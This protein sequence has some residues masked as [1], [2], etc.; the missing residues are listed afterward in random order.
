MG[1]L[2]IFLI[3]CYFGV[4][5]L[6]GGS[7]LLQFY[8]NELVDSRGWMTLEGLGNLLAISQVTPGPIG[9]NLATFI[10]YQQGGF[11]GGL[12]ATIG[13]LTP[14]FFLMSLAVHSYHKWQDSK[15]VRSLLFGVKPVM[16]A[17][18]LTALFACLGMSVLTDE[19]PFDYIY[20][21]IQ[22][23]E[24]KYEE[25]LAIRW[26]TLPVLVLSIYLLRYRKWSIMQV[27]F[28]S[29]VAGVLLQGLTVLIQK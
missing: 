27:I 6:S 4:L 18:I 1:L 10:G 25:D 8:I 17:L 26:Q 13:L 29:A 11:W 3:F 15:L 22:N 16:T 23:A 21:K 14:S 20:Q 28:G 2:G 12:V 24:L 7:S 19:L 5:C 9:V